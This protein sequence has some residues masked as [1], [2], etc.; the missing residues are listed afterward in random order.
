VKTQY[1]I[2]LPHSATDL[3]GWT[4]TAFDFTKIS[5]VGFVWTAVGAGETVYIDG[6]HFYIGTTTTRGRGETLSGSSAVVLDTQDENV[7][8]S[9]NP[10]EN[11][12]PVGR[13]LLISR[14][15]D[16][17]Q[18]ATDPGIW[19]WSGDKSW[20]A[21]EESARKN[22]T[23]LSTFAYYAVVFDINSS[24]IGDNIGPYAGWKQG[25]TENTI[26]VDYYL[27][28]PIG[29]GQSFPQDI[30]HNALRSLTRERTVI[31]R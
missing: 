28:V 6:L 9:L 21:N 10:I 7:A 4:N 24:D 18:V 3:Q 14:L 27:I 29:N 23:V 5:N 26:F 20:F 30:A 8:L 11:Y 2:P 19:V 15:K 31:E 12:L 25:V 22:L 1:T 16:T 17:D 13:Y